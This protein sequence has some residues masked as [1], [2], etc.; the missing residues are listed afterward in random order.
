VGIDLDPVATGR[1]T[2][3]QVSKGDSV[4]YARIERRKLF[5]AVEP[6]SQSAGFGGRKWVEAKLGLTMGTH[7]NTLSS[8]ARFASTLAR[9]ASAFRGS[10]G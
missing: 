8:L 7:K 4:S 2:A 5:R 9:L 1:G 6:I 10:G 3:K